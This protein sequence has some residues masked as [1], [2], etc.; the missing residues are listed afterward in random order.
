MPPLPSNHIFVTAAEILDA[1][2][3]LYAD[4][5]IPLPARQL[6]TEGELAWDCDLVG[7]EL[8]RVYRGQPGFEDPSPISCAGLRTAEFHVWIVRC[9]APMHKDG[10][11]PTVAAIQTVAEEVMTD[12]WLL[13][14]G[15][16]TAINDPDHPLSL[17][18]A[19]TVVGPLNIQGPEGG[20]VGVDLLIQ[21]QLGVV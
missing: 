2:V 20:F 4:E 12:A 15:L 5:S 18:C 17:P 3:D 11:P 9:A 10:S 21:W 16:V 6:V 8:R 19:S 13:P 1:V 14:T 7:V